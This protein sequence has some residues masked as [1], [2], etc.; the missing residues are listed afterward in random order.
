MSLFL[1]IVLSVYGA[2]HVYAF[3][4]IKAAFPFG[5]V[6]GLLLGIFMVT[7][8]FAPALVR[9]LERLGHDCPAR[10]ISYIGYGWMGALFIFFCLSFVSD[11]WRLA[12]YT[13]GFILHRDPAPFVPAA[14]TA[15]LAQVILTLAIAVYGYAEA[16]NIRPE[17]ITIQTPKIPESTGRLRV[18]QISDVHLGIMVRQERLHRI[19]TVI[20]EARP[21]ILVS[22]GD[23]VDGQI[24][25]MQDLADALSQVHPP[26]GKYA[27]TGNHEFYAGLDHA[28]EITARSG[29]TILRN[30]AVRGPITI[31]GVDDP[32]KTPRPGNGISR[33]GCFRPF[34]KTVSPCSSNT[35]LTSA[36]TRRGCSTSSCRA[37]PQG[38][39]LPLA[40]WCGLLPT[41][42]RWHGPA[43][44]VGPV[45]GRAQDLGPA[46]YISLPPS[47]GDRPRSCGE[48][49]KAYPVDQF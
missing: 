27:V 28:L 24:D 16:L 38:T 20:R 48:K 49:W 34:R 14:R 13:A 5:P 23:L 15:F 41:H 7:M 35:S 43:R 4:K 46:P 6:S 21:D 1:F 37:Y 17:F 45:C 3:L 42:R 29:F 8:V 47:H 10:I 40:I 19:L 30:E 11:L 25:G 39:N 2:V 26:L 9:I 33:A 36:Q 22:T 12:A 31:A 44:W 18:V 32:R